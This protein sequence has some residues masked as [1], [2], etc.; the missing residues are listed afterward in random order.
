MNRLAALRVAVLLAGAL[1]VALAQEASDLRMN[2]LRADLSMFAHDSML[3][4]RSGSDAAFRI[5]NAI[6]LRLQSA[7]I[8]PGVRGSYY[9]NVPLVWSR[10]DTANAVMSNNHQT[11]NFGVDYL[12]IPGLHGIPFPRS[13]DVSGVVFGGRLGTP[14]AIDPMKARR[15]LVVMLPPLRANGQP[16]YQVWGRSDWLRRYFAST[17]V[18]VVG[19][20][21][22]PPSIHR[23]MSRPQLE[24]KPSGQPDTTFP[25]V[26]MITR[27]T[28]S[29]FLG[30]H[31]DAAELGKD[32]ITSPGGVRFRVVSEPTSRPARNIVGVI[33][34][35]DPELKSQY[36][37]LSARLDG[38][39]TQAREALPR[40][41]W[42]F[43]SDS[44]M[45]GA[46]EA[47]GA[48]ALLHIAEQLGRDPVRPKRSIMF[49]WTVG[50]DDAAGAKWFMDHSPVSRDNVVANLTVGPVGRGGRK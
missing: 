45:H 48:A 19:L 4:R 46:D 21:L 17:T 36:V 38:T 9:Q 29:L 15:K 7:G 26:V 23:R 32:T 30:K 50:D 33:E 40:S 31:A 11:M 2:A 20:E 12:P 25:A 16:E 8:Q 22:L 5:A 41:L 37:V 35:S 49:L 34:G 39:G 24:V 18:A 3:G 14:T 47:T 27:A 1:N 6:G 28:A 42:P 44:I 13:A 10:L 43:D